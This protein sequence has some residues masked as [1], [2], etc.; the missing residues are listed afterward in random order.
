M[1]R[2]RLGTAAIVVLL[3]ASSGQAADYP[4]LR[5]AYQEGWESTED[6][7]RFELGTAYWYAWGG[8]DAA[9][10]GTAPLGTIG[11]SSRDTSHIGEVQGKIEDL[12]TQTYLSGRAGLGLHTEGSY[13]IS[14]AGTGSIG[15]SSQIGYAGADFGWLPAG[16]MSNGVAFGG[17]VGY[18][19]W[20]DAPAIGSGQYA[21]TFAGGV[22]SVHG[23][24]ANDLDIH[25][26]RLGLRGAADFQM[27]D[28]QAEVAAVP[29]AQITGTLGG[30][31]PNGFSFGGTT[32]YERAPTNLSGR[33]YGVMAEAML[34]F[35]PTENLTLRFGGRAWYLEGPM[36][37]SFTSNAGGVNRAAA[38]LQSSYA[39]FFRYGLTGQII[40]RF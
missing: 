20:K 32:Y 31:S 33:G 29:Y 35:R 37:A 22:P 1:T 16:T 34:G 9:Y 26:L 30:S 40:G 17:L 18:H 8:Q 15:R 6:S 28:V 14:P 13:S 24:A 38:T 2:T 27:F 25:A 36:E 23:P 5:P 19:Y 3:A 7:I 11:V 21:T 39:S 4:E 12:S 10:A